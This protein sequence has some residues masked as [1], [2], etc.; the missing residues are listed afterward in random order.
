MLADHQL[1]FQRLQQFGN[2][3]GQQGA[4]LRRI[5]GLGGLDAALEVFQQVFGGLHAGIGHEQGGFEVFVEFLVDSG[6]GKDG[7]DAAAGAA[8]TGLEAVEPAG[9]GGGFGRRRVA[10]CDRL[11]IGWLQRRGGSIC[12][13]RRDGGRQLLGGALRRVFGGE[14]V[15]GCRRI[16]GIFRRG[17]EGGFGQRGFVDRGRL[18]RGGA[19]VHGIVLQRLDQCLFGQG[20]LGGRGR[21]LRAAC[22][23]FFA[24]KAAAQP[25]E[26]AAGR[27]RRLRGGRRLGRC[28]RCL[29]LRFCSRRWRSLGNGGGGSGFGRG[30][31]FLEET[32]HDRVDWAQG[33]QSPHCTNCMGLAHD[34]RQDIWR[35]RF[36]IL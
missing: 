18:E 19:A 34:R 35:R 36:F 12:P 14:P 2:G 15:L 31:F 9:A 25:V 32:E 29:H 13:S 17:S 30:R 21:S 23:V 24:A 11:V 26:P 5:G 8:Q 7:G 22:S 27:R 1:L 33:K 16:V 4:H 6:A 20:Q 3:I 10:G 28:S